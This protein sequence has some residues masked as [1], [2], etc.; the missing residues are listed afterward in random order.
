LPNFFVLA[1]AGIQRLLFK[2]RFGTSKNLIVFLDN[3]GPAQLIVRQLGETI[4]T[5]QKIISG[6]KP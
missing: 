5:F 3:C 2:A 1:V 4:D 6:H